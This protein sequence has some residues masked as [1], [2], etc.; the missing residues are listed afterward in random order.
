MKNGKCYEEIILNGFCVKNVHST[1]LN[2]TMCFRNPADKTKNN[3]DTMT[4]VEHEAIVVVHA[5]VT[6]CNLKIHAIKPLSNADA[7]I[8]L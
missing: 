8:L 4:Q 5:Q 3:A 6:Q 7:Q 2:S 1:A